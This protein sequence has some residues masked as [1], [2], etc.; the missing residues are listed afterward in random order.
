MKTVILGKENSSSYQSHNSAMPLTDKSKQ[1]MAKSCNTT[2]K[3]PAT[4]L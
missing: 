2:Y 4:L 1:S 3:L